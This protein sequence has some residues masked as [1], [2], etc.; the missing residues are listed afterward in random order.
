[1]TTTLA[2]ITY[3]TFVPSYFQPFICASRHVVA[4][5]PHT[6]WFSP[7]TSFAFEKDFRQGE[8]TSSG[9]CALGEL[10]DLGPVLCNELIRAKWQCHKAQPQAGL[11]KATSLESMRICGS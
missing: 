4:E 8:R 7:N 11:W 10:L 2:T 6:S 3:S 1:M 9:S 5:K